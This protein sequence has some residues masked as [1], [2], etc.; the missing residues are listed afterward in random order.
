MRAGDVVV[1]PQRLAHTDGN[2]LLADVEVR[3]PRH[4]RA[5]VE[6]VD[7]LLKQTDRHHLA[8]EPEQLLGRD[9]GRGGLDGT[10]AW[11][12]ASWASTWNTAAKSF[13]AR[14]VAR[15]A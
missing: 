2:R 3:E 12:P 8:I 14:P 13:S 10:H 7:A 11:T 6:V 9:V 1:G 15:P 5:G 4:Q